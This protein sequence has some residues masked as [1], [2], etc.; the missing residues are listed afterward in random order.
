MF[1]NCKPIT[2]LTIKMQFWLII[3]VYELL[4]LIIDKYYLDFISYS[5]Y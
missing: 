2:L 1:L 5:Y 3:S 4:G